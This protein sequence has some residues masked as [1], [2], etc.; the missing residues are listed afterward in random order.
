[1]S[2]SPDS[3][4]SDSIGQK[5]P[6][7]QPPAKKAEDGPKCEACRFWVEDK[8]PGSVGRCGECRRNPPSVLLDS[9]DAMMC[10]WP[11]TDDTHWCGEFRQ[12]VQ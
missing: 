1:M 3:A 4:D 8:E 12:R 11:F 7:K 6:K 9:E 2:N 10:I 5:V